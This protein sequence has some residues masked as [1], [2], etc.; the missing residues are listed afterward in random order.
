ME[1]PTT[2]EI[3]IRTADVTTKTLP[4]PPPPRTASPHQELVERLKD[5]G[6][7]DV[8]AL[9]EELSPE[10]RHLLVTEIE[11]ICILYSAN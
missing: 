11:V 9:W 5:Y 4:P 2:E 7:E 8:F 10:E 3:E 1:E 6:Q